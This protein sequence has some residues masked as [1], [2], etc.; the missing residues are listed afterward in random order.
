MTL[1]H[2]LEWF[3]E[4]KLIM[5]FLWKEHYLNPLIP[6]ELTKLKSSGLLDDK[7]VRQVMDEFLP[8]FEAKLPSGMYFPVP[9]SRTIKQGKAFTTELAIKFHYNFIQVDE[10]QKWSLPNK[11]IS[12]KVLALFESNLFFEK[13]TGLYFV[14]YWSDT[15]WDKCY[16][17]CAVTPLLALAIDRNHEELKVQ[18]NNQKT[19][20]LDLN[21]FR[22]DSAERCFVRTL[23][24]GEVLLADSPRFWF[25]NNLDESGSH[26]ILGE[27]HF[28][29]SF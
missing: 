3:F 21:S 4:R 5:F 16:L 13:E 17:E 28:P 12:G 9:I 26:F 29:L 1:E 18:L 25:L 7:C 24:Y 19:D 6:E 10:N 23:N 15:R 27:N 22:I 20:S 11:F 8:E 2:R 14:E